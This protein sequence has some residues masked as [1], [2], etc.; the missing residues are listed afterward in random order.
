MDTDSLVASF[1]SEGSPPPK[2]R[3]LSEESSDPD[4]DV[5]EEKTPCQLGTCTCAEERPRAQWTCPDPPEGYAYLNCRVK[6]HKDFDVVA[7]AHEHFREDY[8]I[9]VVTHLFGKK[10][11]EKKHWHIHGVYARPRKTA[12]KSWYKSPHP[13]REQG[14]KPF[15]SHWFDK[16]PT[17]GFQYCVKSPERIGRCPVVHMHRLTEGD[18][19]QI[20]QQS[21]EA[22]QSFE[23]ELES[24]AKAS[25]NV[26]EP[27]IINHRRLHVLTTKYYHAKDRKLHA[28]IAWKVRD[29]LAK[30]HPD[31]HEYIADK[32][33]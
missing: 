10:K 32:Y 16:T 19:Y 12:N 9:L 25:I 1:L 13:L 26:A 11:G 2:K 23:E 17:N 21:D 18:M 3:K 7:F 33:M 20:M 15:S 31:G 4:S 24:S 14:E 30:W 29:W 8:P 28:G 6:Y 22:V 5:E 27:P